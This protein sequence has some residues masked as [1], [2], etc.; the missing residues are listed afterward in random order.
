MTT[1]VMIPCPAKTTLFDK[2]V[3]DI[4]EIMK[5]GSALQIEDTGSVPKESQNV[6]LV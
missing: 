3:L 4:Y 6:S 1:A 2:V 5:F